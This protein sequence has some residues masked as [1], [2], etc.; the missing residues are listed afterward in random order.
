MSDFFSSWT[1]KF[2]NAAGTVEYCGAWVVAAV[3]YEQL[4]QFYKQT[5]AAA[6]LLAWTG[7]IEY[8]E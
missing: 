6:D 8:P 7:N 1:K 3:K 5:A 4:C 2:A